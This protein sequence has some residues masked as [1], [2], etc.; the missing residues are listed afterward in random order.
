MNLILVIVFPLQS[1]ILPIKL[2]LPFNRKMDGT[3]LCIDPH[4]TGINPQLEDMHRI[5]ENEPYLSLIPRIINERQPP[6]YG[7]HYYQ[8]R[9]PYLE[10]DP[11]KSEGNRLVEAASFTLLHIPEYHD[12]L[13]RVYPFI[14]LILATLLQWLVYTP[15]KFSN[16]QMVAAILQLQSVVNAQ[17]QYLQYSNKLTQ[18]IYLTYAI[19]TANIVCISLMAYINKAKEKGHLPRL[20]RMKGS[21]FRMVS[22]IPSYYSI[23]R[24]S[25]YIFSPASLVS[26]SQLRLLDMQLALFLIPI[27]SIRTD[28]LTGEQKELKWIW[29]IVAFVV[30]SIFS[31]CAYQEY[32]KLKDMTIK[33]HKEEELLDKIKLSPYPEPDWTAEQVGHWIRTNEEVRDCSA[34]TEGELAAI[35]AKFVATGVHGI[36][37]CKVA[38]DKDLLKEDVGLFV[39]E[40]L[41]FVHTMEKL[42]SRKGSPCMTNKYRLT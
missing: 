14:F 26:A 39:G 33:K 28:P 24:S 42:R 3:I 10:S 30:L 37:F 2:H 38:Y 6:F 19:I 21:I 36:A 16:A 1:N 32:A 31:I 13:S 34:L 8:M 22:K 41:L 40:Q 20:V 35:A 29:Y 5:N 11:E 17:K 4:F 7:E 25:M 23:L 18:I 15:D 12:G 9:N 27:L